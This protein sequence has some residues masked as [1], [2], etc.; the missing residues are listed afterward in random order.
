MI[1]SVAIFSD[2]GDSLDNRVDAQ[3]IVSCTA[4]HTHTHAH[5]HTRTRANTHTDTHTHTHTH[6]HTQLAGYVPNRPLDHARKIMGRSVQELL[7]LRRD[8]MATESV[9]CKQS[10]RRQSSE[11]GA[12]SRKPRPNYHSVDWLDSTVRL[13]T[14][15][16]MTQAPWC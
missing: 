1:E 6:T 4:Q 5:T 8:E 14:S 7:C 12:T 15:G 3:I 13:E 16:E 10:H 2:K 9:G 11:G